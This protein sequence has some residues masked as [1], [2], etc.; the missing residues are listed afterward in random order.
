MGA[1][2]IKMIKAIKMAKKVKRRAGDVRGWG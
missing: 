2:V 1:K